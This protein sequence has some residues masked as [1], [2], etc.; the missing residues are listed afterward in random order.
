M[1]ATMRIRLFV[2]FALGQ[3]CTGPVFGQGF[4]EVNLPD[5]EM[6]AITSSA[7][8]GYEYGVWVALPAG[9]SESSESYPVLYFLDASSQFGMVVQTYRL[10]RAGN[11][12]PPLLIVGI[13][14]TGDFFSFSDRARDFMPT[15][16]SQDQVREKYGSAMAGFLPVSGGDWCASVHKYDI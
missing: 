6:R 3:F 13:A 11:E 15:E 2:L 10:L 14:H 5:T 7:V 1:E 16:L 9:Y 8:S 12:I 4:P